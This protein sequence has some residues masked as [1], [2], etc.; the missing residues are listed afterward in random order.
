MF[1]T[2]TADVNEELGYLKR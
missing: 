1:I 2:T